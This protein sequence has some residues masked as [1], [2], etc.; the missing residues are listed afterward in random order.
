MHFPIFQLNRNLFSKEPI[1]GVFSVWGEIGVG[2]TT[3]AIQTA[4]IN[5]LDGKKIIYIFS[6]PNFPYEK[7]KNFIHN[8]SNNILDNIQ[9]IQILDYEEL[10]TIIFNLEFNI[11]NS[12]KVGG[13]LINLIIIDSITNL[14][15][16]ELNRDDKEKNFVLNYKLNQILANLYN[17]NWK[18]D[19]EI[20]IINEVS[21]TEINGEPIQIQSGGKIMEYW[22]SHSLKIE[23]TEKLNYRKLI[24]S[25]REEKNPKHYFSILSENGFK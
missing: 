17:L 22:I 5:A 6:K 20:L 25:R 18:Y 21:Q 12:L 16:L 7:I 1:K 23:R 10:Y 3:F 14:Y 15:R 11:L 2:K 19:T 24:L 13:T 4:I 8:H 9:F